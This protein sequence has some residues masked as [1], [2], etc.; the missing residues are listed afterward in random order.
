MPNTTFIIPVKLDSSQRF[1]NIEITLR[2]LLKHTDSNIII[3]ECDNEQKLFLPEL[4]NSRI[5]YN[6][7]KSNNNEF[8]RTKLINNML[9]VVKTNFVSNY[10]VDVL[11]PA[12]A[13]KKCE[14]LLLTNNADVVYPYGF[15]CFDQRKIFDDTE[16]IELFKSTL[17][18]DDLKMDSRS[19]HFCRYGHIQYFKTDVYKKGY[20]ENE[21]YKHWCPEDEERGIRFK[22]LGYNV[23]WFRSLIYHQEH[24]PSVIKEPN[25]KKEIYDLHNTLINMTKEQLI[26]Y[27][28][29]QEY[30]TKYEN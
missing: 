27:Y 13:Y 20:M 29:K 26:E 18:L 17:N 9:S 12:S 25:N 14:D 6:F 16:G 4:K 3:T 19:I 2:Y 30:I 1:Q 21:N 28:N 8:H 15:E 24:P 7:V 11:L 10:D 5:N 22:K 23:V